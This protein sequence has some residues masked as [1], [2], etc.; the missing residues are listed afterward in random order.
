MRCASDSRV[1]LAELGLGAAIA[2]GGFGVADSWAWSD[3]PGSGRE[4]SDRG[5]AGSALGC[6]SGVG[7]TRAVEPGVSSVPAVSGAGGGGVAASGWL[8][9]GVG[10]GRGGA[11]ASCTGR[12]VSSAARAALASSFGLAH[13]SEQ[14][15]DQDD[16]EHHARGV[17]QGPPPTDGAR[18]KR[19]GVAKNSC[20][21]RPACSRQRGS[22]WV[23]CGRM[24]PEVIAGSSFTNSPSQKTCLS[25]RRRPTISRGAGSGRALVRL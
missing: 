14:D 7:V 23:A 17:T 6:S 15:H 24:S 1:G 13:G 16:M 10:A 9:R 11:N 2:E 19:G 22:A 8:T 5:A 12:E 18:G 20:R 3:A 4:A 25:S 21:H